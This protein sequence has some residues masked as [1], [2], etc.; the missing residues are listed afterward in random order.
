MKM[1][2]LTTFLLKKSKRR[3][4]GFVTRLPKTQRKDSL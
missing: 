4:V 2:L 1:R 3:R